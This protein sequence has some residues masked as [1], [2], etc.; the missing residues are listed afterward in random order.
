[1]PYAL[2]LPDGRV[3]SDIPDNVS[4]EEVYRKL[5]SIPQPKTALEQLGEVKPE[6]GVLEAVGRGAKRGFAQMKSAF[7]DVLPAMA[8]SS[9]GLDEYAR[10]QMEEARQ[11]QE[12][13]AAFNPAQFGSYKEVTGPMSALTYG[14]ET[15]GELSP[16]I[17]AAL[18][19]GGIG[20]A[21]GRRVA[22]GAAERALGAGAAEELAAAGATGATRGQIAGTYL[23]SYAQNAPEVFQNIYESSGGKLEPAAA[24]LASAVSAGLDSIL[25]AQLLRNLTGPAKKGIVDRILEESGM[26]SGLARTVTAGVI[27]G[28]PQEGLT[29][30]AQEA[31]SIA[32]EKFVND[33]KDVWSS[34]EWNRIIESS[35]KGAVGGAFFGGLG[36]GAERL[37]ERRQERQEAARDLALTEG[38]QQE[39]YA[40]DQARQAELDAVNARVT[41]NLNLLRQPL[42]DEERTQRQADLEAA[43]KDYDSYKVKV[44]EI[45]EANALQAEEAKMAEW[46]AGINEK[47]STPEGVQETIKK[48]NT[49]Q[50]DFPQFNKAQ[51]NQIRTQLQRRMKAFETQNEDVQNTTQ[52]ELEKVFAKVRPTPVT[53]LTPETLDRYGFSEK[54]QRE[55]AGL[56]LRKK[57]NYQ[58][59]MDLADN[60]DPKRADDSVAAAKYIELLPKSITEQKVS[61]TASARNQDIKASLSKEAKDLL[62]VW[63]T[64]NEEQASADLSA[65]DSGSEV[66]GEGAGASVGMPAERLG[67]EVQETQEPAGGGL[68]DTSL[69]AERGVGDV[70][71]GTESQ[72]SALIHD[73]AKPVVASWEQKYTKEDLVKDNI[74]NPNFDLLDKRIADFDRIYEELLPLDKKLGSMQK[75]RR[76]DM[77][78]SRQLSEELKNNWQYARSAAGDKFYDPRTQLGRLLDDVSYL[79]SRENLDKLKEHVADLKQRGTP[80]EAA[81]PV[82]EAPAPKGVPVSQ[83]PRVG[84]LLGALTTGQDLQAYQEKKYGKVKSVSQAAEEALPAPTP[85][86]DDLE[87]TKTKAKDTIARGLEQAFGTKASIA[88]EDQ[89]SLDEVLSAVADLMYVYIKQGVKSMGEAIRRARKDMGEKAKGITH[90]QMV[91]AFN[92]ATDRVSEEQRATKADASQPK[93]QMKLVEQSI[94]ALPKPSRAIAEGAVDALSKLPDSLQANV[95]SI[96]GLSQKYEM[97]GKDLPSIK[98]LETAV[99]LRAG[100]FMEKQR[101]IK[102][103]LDKGYGLIKKY[104]TP[105]LDKF[106]RIAMDST[107]DQIELI[108]SKGADKN[109]ALYRQ[110]KSLPEEY[111]SLYKEIRNAYE[112]MANEY[113]EF[114]TSSISDK[115][116][117]MKLRREFET[118]R[119]KVYLPMMRYGEYWLEYTDKNGDR[120]VEAFESPAQ[121]D[122]VQA[123]LAREGATGF[124]PYARLSQIAAIREQLPAGFMSQLVNMMRREGASDELVDNAYQAYLSLFPA[125]SIRQQFKYREG[126]SGYSLDVLQGFA[127]VG[128]RM[129]RQLSQL[130]FN[131]QVDKAMANIVNEAGPRPTTTIAS[132]VADLRKEMDYMKNPDHS[133]W[134]QKASYLSYFNYILGNVSS[135]IINLTNLPIMTYSV[136]GGEYGFGKAFTAMQRAT[137]MYAKGG[138]NEE[139]D[140]T[141]STKADGEIKKLL[142]VA[143]SRAAIG[144]STGY[145]LV[146]MMRTKAEDY[147][148]TRAKIEKGLGWVFQNSEQMNREIGIISTYMLAREKGM[149][150]AEATEKA[151]QTSTLVNGSALSETGPR[152]F[153]QGIGRVLFIFKRFAQA[154]MYMAIRLTHQAFK[155]ETPD[156]RRMAMRQLMGLMGTSFAFAG[157]QGMPF[158]GGATVMYGMLN[159][160]LGDDDDEFFDADEALSSALGDVAY[161]G[162]VNAALNIDIASRTGFGN[163]FWRDD[164]R[165]LSEVG[166]MVYT[167][168]RIAGPAYS[169]GLNYERA[170]SLFKQGQTERAIETALPSFMRNVMKATRFAT[171]GATNLDGVP[172]I[173]DVGTYNIVMQLMGF[174][175]AELTEAYA[176]AGARKQAEKFIMDRRQALLN[177]AYLAKSNGDTEG[178]DLIQE[179]IDS[180]NDKYPIKGIKI[181]KDTLNRSYNGHLQRNKEMIDGVR[182]NPKLKSYLLENVSPDEDEEEF[183]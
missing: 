148:G 133:G 182:Y 136:L 79:P 66:I 122:R 159:A 50:T 104:G 107:R 16:Q 179:K 3:I 161:R 96:F 126:I 169:V 153:Q 56:N 142:E 112:E 80:V 23:G 8:A 46:R 154:Q 11:S 106:N 84:G 172:I 58:K 5:Q 55:L 82:E 170:Y 131:P 41:E 138:L 101:A 30:G 26:P 27:K 9:V 163:L 15:I 74:E 95:M 114:I 150:P 173:D 86:E 174:S 31:I 88:P 141:A 72:P 67:T 33:N 12:E 176:R 118:G 60:Q 132:V 35:V 14:A 1:M 44:K 147:T 24:A 43:L 19:P 93:Q 140:W 94:N 48:L 22:L 139:G 109:T 37:S 168:E 158:V 152:L 143:R 68:G 28:I 57:E 20:G 89:V 64:T 21:V 39:V 75:P 111:Q 100:R 105:T 137:S 98:A 181:S 130:E 69:A 129:A 125:Q 42:N 52:A 157:V 175:D 6:Y 155:G 47:L 178:M 164:S 18:I 17:A 144:R 171:E 91:D 115:S 113:L 121:R 180:F 71:V 85:E 119:L 116:A 183:E 123:L 25:P 145:E 108:D 54:A 53:E 128:T 13:I 40:Q 165:R 124:K 134:T 135:A 146:E 36:G 10:R 127:N 32:A 156:I 90:A 49:K 2:R 120:S 29:E 45:E 177:L 73:P 151:I 78:R 59:L 167:L 7:G 81:A 65:Q 92:T 117:A 83:V 63:E 38:A 162:P 4:K 61:P 102:R 160:L 34:P 87:V 62:D 149:T 97:F 70:G 77:D 166:P 99:E 76:A 110:F 103:V 51:Q